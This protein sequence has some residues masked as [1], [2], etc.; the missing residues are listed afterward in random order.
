M[1][2]GIQHVHRAL[3][4][5][6]LGA[7]QLLRLSAGQ[8]HLAQERPVAFRR[9][10]LAHE[11]D[12]AAAVGERQDAGATVRR[13]GDRRARVRVRVLVGELE[14]DAAAVR[15]ARVHDVAPGHARGEPRLHDQGQVVVTPY[16]AAV[17]E[18][19]VH[20][21]RGLAIERRLQHEDAVPILGLLAGVALVQRLDPG[22]GGVGVGAPVHRAHARGHRAEARRHLL[23]EGQLG[24][25]RHRAPV[26]G[27][28]HLHRL[29]EAV[30]RHQVRERL[31]DRLHQDVASVGRDVGARDDP[32]IEQRPGPAV[33]LHPDQLRGGVVL[34][35]RLVVRVLQ[36]VLVR[37]HRR[38]LAHVLLDH[39]TRGHH[40]LL[41]R[42]ATALGHQPHDQRTR[43]GRPVVRRAE[44]GVVHRT[45][46]QS[47]GTGVLH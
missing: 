7:E 37:P 25:G 34:E 42:R 1:V 17:A 38:R 12:G 9:R 28:D 3:V 44:H 5:R 11:V 14:Q 19:Q 35:Q 10:A 45:V 30:G 16:D 15:V 13:V 31:V 36:Q 20:E 8:V 22:Q 39:R 32:G 43:V 24:D 27:R 2:V 26:P 18:L 47:P 40:G 33:Q 4:E 46:Q 23:L 21:T 6:R 29:R 41:G